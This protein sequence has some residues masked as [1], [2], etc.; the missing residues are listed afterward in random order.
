MEIA[1]VGAGPV[2]LYAAGL[3]T[4]L[5]PDGHVQVFEK[6]SEDQLSGFGYTIH[7]SSLEL[8]GVLH[9]DV[10]TSIKEKGTEPFTSRTFTFRGRKAGLDP[11]VCRKMPIIG[12]EYDSLTSALKTQAAVSGVELHYKKIV[13]DIDRL[14]Q[15]ND[16]VIVANGANSA[17]L[18]RFKPLKLD[19]KLSYAWGKK[20]KS[21]DEMA[22]S[23][24]TVD[25][26]T[27][28]CHKYPI[29]KSTTA[30]IIEVLEHQAADAEKKFDL[31]P[32][33]MQY[34]P[35][36]I[37][38]RKVPLGLCRK[39]AHRNIVCIG[40]AA[41]AQYF[42]AG[43]GLYFGL[44]QTGMLFHHLDVTP[45]SIEQK[46]K[47]YDSK[48]SELIR[49]QWEPNKSLIR[50]KQRLLTDFTIMPDD[51]VLHALLTNEEGE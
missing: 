41:L 6:R 12:I 23:I 4:R 1:V 19:T 48:V 42:G 38:F 9:P 47:T 37:M 32:Q 5:Y 35:E 31:A 43:A 21:S 50:K 25:E 15:D 39:R 14:A 24:D 28:T 44:M 18:E 7:D 46:L 10:V 45:G 11:E 20:E 30:V 22:M 49:Q 51:T 33:T 40:D 16:L 13:T 36:G 34:F 17:F 29:S 2:G 3:L 27:F 8:L 26:I